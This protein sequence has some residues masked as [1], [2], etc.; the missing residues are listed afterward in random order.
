MSTE[1]RKPEGAR[2]TDREQAR[3]ILT[4]KIESS[5]KLI[6]D[7]QGFSTYSPHE[8]IRDAEFRL[9]WID[10][11]PEGANHLV[12]PLQGAYGVPMGASAGYEVGPGEGMRAAIEE[13]HGVSWIEYARALWTPTPRDSEHYVEGADVLVSEL[14]GYKLEQHRPMDCRGY[15]LDTRTGEYTYGCKCGKCGGVTRLH[16]GRV[17]RVVYWADN[18]IEAFV[19][20]KGRDERKIVTLTAAHGDVC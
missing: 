17:E 13:L 12:A 5:H 2:H 15:G 1:T 18:S 8:L 3:D 20:I 4:R 9:R 19:K 16:W 14:T 6:A 10:C 11:A 7:P